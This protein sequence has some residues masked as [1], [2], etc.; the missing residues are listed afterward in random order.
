MRVLAVDGD[1]ATLELSGR[2]AD[3]P[4]QGFT[5]QTAESEFHRVVRHETGHTLGFPH[6]HMRRE[7]VQRIDPEKAYK[8]F[9]ATQGW[10]K[11]QVDQQVLTPLG[12]ASIFGTPADQDSIM[13]YQLPGSITRGRPHPEPDPHGNLPISADSAFADADCPDNCAHTHRKCR[14]FLPRPGGRAHPGRGLAHSHRGR[15]NGR[16]PV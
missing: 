12:E 15:P 5:M 2:C 10:T 7:L 9:A 11:Q 6:E 4:L 14:H 13:C 3:C 8:Y 1:D 16:N